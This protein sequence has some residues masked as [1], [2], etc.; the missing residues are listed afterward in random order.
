LEHQVYGNFHYSLALVILVDFVV[1]DAE[2]GQ[3]MLVSEEHYL[4]VKM[5]DDCHRYY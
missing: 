2:I 5:M 3:L 4:D 1:L